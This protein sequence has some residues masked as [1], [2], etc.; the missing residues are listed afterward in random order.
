MESKTFVRR[1]PNFSLDMGEARVLTSLNNSPFNCYINTPM[2]S[3][4]N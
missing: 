1:W 2:Q 4:S 3:I